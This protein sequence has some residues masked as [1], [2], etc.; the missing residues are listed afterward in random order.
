M[1][2]G[3][4]CALRR[5]RLELPLVLLLLGWACTA[6]NPAFH[7]PAPAADAAGELPDAAPPPP[8]LR[9]PPAD[10]APPVPDA[11]PP[12]DA[13]AAPDAAIAPPPDAAP[14]LAADRAPPGDALLVVGRTVMAAL[15][16]QLEAS[17]KRLGFTV[18]VRDAP[19]SV[20]NDALG[21]S[22]VV[23]SG[24][25]YSDDV[26]AKFR[27][28]P[29]PVVVFDDAVFGAMKMTGSRSGTDFGSVLDERRLMITND[30]HPLAGG[31][32]GLVTVA[33]AGLQ[34]SWGVPSDAAIKV[35]TVVDQPSRYT[36]FAYTEGSTMVGMTA[37]ARR[38]GAFVRFP[39]D[40][41]Y[42][43]SGLMLFEAAA[44]W[45]IGHLD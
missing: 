3:S 16:A 5:P 22:L 12:E 42:T 15:D 31:L 37:P 29:V 45:A 19:A 40:A 7:P 32:S 44:L 11:A 18:T 26:G 39:E 6:P 13:A 41:T 23:I 35:A 33:S 38:V 20:A 21:R 17:L 28:V 30:A 27:D 36:I 24:S 14:D 8:D 2:S 43:E 4:R 34:I 25:A 1:R 10:E 9:A